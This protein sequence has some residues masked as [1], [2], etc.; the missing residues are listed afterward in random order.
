MRSGL[1][2]A[3][4]SELEWSVAYHGVGGSVLSPMQLSL[5]RLGLLVLSVLSALPFLPSIACCVFDDC[6][7]LLRALLDGKKLH[8]RP[9]VV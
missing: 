6:D 7:C 4:L 2:L 5:Y 8:V 3:L 9:L 1:A